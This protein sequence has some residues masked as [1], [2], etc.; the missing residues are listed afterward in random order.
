MRRRGTP[1]Q[2]QRAIRSTAER[3][4]RR[5]IVDL[6]QDPGKAQIR[7]LKGQLAGFNMRSSPESGA[8]E[9][10]AEALSGQ[11]ETGSV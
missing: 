11:T 6:P 7:Y 10:R 5:V 9:T 8:K 2:A 3:D 4:G 1:K